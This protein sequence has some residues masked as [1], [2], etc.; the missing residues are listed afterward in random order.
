MGLDKYAETEES[1]YLNNEQS[2][3]LM[4]LVINKETGAH[5]DPAEPRYDDEDSDLGRSRRCGRYIY[6]SACVGAYIRFG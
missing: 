4:L 1:N 2:D 5:A 3:F 6:R